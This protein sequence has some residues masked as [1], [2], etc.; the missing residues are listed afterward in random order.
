MPPLPDR[1]LSRSTRYLDVRQHPEAAVS[2]APFRS[3]ELRNGGTAVLRHGPTQGVTFLK[4][5]P[6]H[7]QVSIASGDG[8]VIEKCKRKC[9]RGYELEIEIVTGRS[10]PVS[11][12]LP[13]GGNPETRWPSDG[14]SS[15]CLPSSDG[16]ILS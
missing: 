5:S 16:Q 9:D 12:P 7:T 4:G 13:S 8:L 10:S 15:A 3:V 6:D 14:M 11:L 2:L 1:S